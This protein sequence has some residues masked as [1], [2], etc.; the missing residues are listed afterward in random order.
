MTNHLLGG[1]FGVGASRNF[2]IFHNY[3]RNVN[4]G[5]NFD[6]YPAR[7][8]DIFGNR[9][10]H[11]IVWGVL[12]NNGSVLKNIKI[13]DNVIKMSPGAGPVFLPGQVRASVKIYRNRVVQPN[14]SGGIISG[15]PKLTGTFHD[16]EIQSAGPLE[17]NS[18][19]NLAVFGNCDR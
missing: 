16:N 11:V 18:V 17:T 6:T 2:K 12:F 3:A 19:P 8:L 7:N 1:A 15:S 4:I 13:H 10:D 9:L 14:P 5:I